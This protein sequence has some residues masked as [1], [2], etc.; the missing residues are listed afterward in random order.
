MLLE[1]VQAGKERCGELEQRLLI[2]LDEGPADQHVE[3]RCFGR[4]PALVAEIGFVHVPMERRSARPQRW[5]SSCSQRLA[6]GS[7]VGGDSARCTSASL[8]SYLG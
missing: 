5:P 1:L 3:A 6:P 4:I 7:L 8:V 2:M